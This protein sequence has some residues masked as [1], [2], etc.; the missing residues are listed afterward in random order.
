VTG[1]WTST[2]ETAG[3]ATIA[4]RHRLYRHAALLVLTLATVITFSAAC[5]DDDAGEEPTPTP[6]TAATR[7]PR[8]TSTR[9]PEPTPTV[10]SADNAMTHLRVLAEDIGIRNAGSTNERRAADYI[11]NELASY[12][13]DAQ[14]QP[15]TFP[16]Y[17][18]IQSD[19][20]IT[21]PGGYT[22][23]A[24]G[25]PP[26]PDGDVS[27]PVVSAGY[28]Y[29]Q[30]IPSDAAGKIILVQRGEIGAAEKASNAY[31]AGAIG[32]IVFNYEPGNFYGTMAQASRIPVMAISQEDGQALL[33]QIADGAVSARIRL[34][35]ARQDTESWNVVARDPG[36]ECRIVVGGHL[37]SVPAGPGANDNGS[38]TA[39]VLEIA[40]V[41]AADGVPEDVCYVLFGSEES[42]LLGSAH[43]V[44]ALSDAEREGM[45]AMLN[46][47]MLAVGQGWPLL[48]S[49]DM[50]DIAV[51]EA[52]RLGLSY[53]LSN[54]LPSNVGSDHANF[55]RAGIPTLFFNCFCDNNWHT[56]ADRIEAI[57]PNRIQEAGDLGLAVLSRLLAEGSGQ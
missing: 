2:G 54:E 22:I 4:R 8:A 7:T 52:E 38:G 53:R 33:D 13:Y 44:S 5:G 28:G 11:R 27:G 29:P 37:D 6:R 12:G 57:E 35:T 23:D 25:L 39:T 24:I 31:L 16:T 18:D 51:G 19:V 43:Y 15:F 55:A 21:S 56:P 14:L 30:E 1:Q 10:F 26:S 48:G 36:R 32:L 3:T 20:D 17:I 9:T 40:R 41:R 50:V 34:E 42:G 49:E 47:D 45:R 46:F